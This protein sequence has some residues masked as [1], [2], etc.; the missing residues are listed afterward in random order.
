RYPTILEFGDALEN[1]ARSDGHRA[2]TRRALF[3]TMG[4]CVGA[5]ALLVFRNSLPTHEPTDAKSRIR[6]SEHKFATTPTA[7][8]PPKPIVGRSGMNLVSIPAGEFWM[9]SPEADSDAR[10]NE[11]PLHRVTISR[12]F[13][14]GVY[15]V[16]V[17]QFRAF[18]ERTSY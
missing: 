15:E 8:P 18:V 3:A 9:G 1:A 11:K 4:A 16:T 5:P 14:L 2:R 7:T 17:E 12:P 10:P 13:H 6:R